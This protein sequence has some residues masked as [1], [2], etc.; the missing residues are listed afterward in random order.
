MADVANVSEM[1]VSRVLSGKGVVSKRTRAH[2]LKVVDGLGYVQNHLAGSLA[3]SRSNQVAVIIPSLMNNVFSQVMAGITEALER[4]GY[5]A[6]VGISDY[7]VEKEES[8]VISMMSWR[9]AGMI[10][11]NLVHTERTRSILANASVPVVEMMDISGEPID[12]CVGLDHAKAATAMADHLIAKGYTRFGY[13]GWNNHDFAAATRFSAIR[14]RLAKAG[15]ALVAPDLFDRPPDFADGKSGLHALLSAEPE[16]EVVIYSNDTAA[17]GGVIHCL[18]N[19]IDMP[20]D[21][22]L[23]GFSG[24]QIGQIMPRPLTTI[25]SKRYDTGRIAARSVINALAGQSVGK[26]IDLGFELVEGETA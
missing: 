26:V 14:E 16:L 4:A 11:T 13:L 20:G 12:I 9:P 24:L 5:N 2:V 7:S 6:V 22:A 25:R 15:L 19:G 8:L 10:V 23:A 17:A 3:T 18:E 21:L 1:T